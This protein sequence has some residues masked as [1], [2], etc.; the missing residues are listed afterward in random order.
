[1]K[2]EFVTGNIIKKINWKNNLYL[3]LDDIFFGKN[4]YDIN[5]IVEISSGTNLLSPPSIIINSI[6]DIGNKGQKINYYSSPLG[7]DVLRESILIYENVLSNFSLPKSYKSVVTNGA[8]DGLRIVFNYLKSKGKSRVLTLGPQYSI[9]YQIINLSNLEFIESS[10]IGETFLPSSESIKSIISSSE[11]DILFMTQP[12]NPTGE[13]YSTEEFRKIIRVAKENDLILVYEK[14]GSDIQI[15]DFNSEV[16]Y[17]RVINEENYWKN[18]IIIDS[19]SKRRAISG[20]RIGYILGEKELEDHANLVRFGD[21]PPLI[22]NEGIFKDLIMSAI[23]HIAE[24]EKLPLYASLSSL[25]SN[26]EINTKDIIDFLESPSLIPLIETHYKEIEYLYRNIY[27]NLNRFKLKF[28]DYIKGSTSMTSGANCLIALDIPSISE[29]EAAILLYES[30][31]TITYPLGCFFIDQSLSRRISDK[32]WFRLSTA[33]EYDD[34][35][36]IISKLD[37]FL[38]SGEISENKQ[39]N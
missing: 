14:L 39:F 30:G 33:M 17:G 22:G 13:V 32:F 35:D 6:K 27:D 10:G 24:R 3:F 15:G 16:E 25:K 29:K 26:H 9:V 23:I 8:A 11:C 36:K 18:T 31:K 4:S 34:F 12:N 1:M 21:C 20:L 7:Q 38:M 5:E 19:F 28:K 2:N 37:N